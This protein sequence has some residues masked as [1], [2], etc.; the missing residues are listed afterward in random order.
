MHENEKRN[1]VIALSLKV[2]PAH[3][4]TVSRYIHISVYSFHLQ[5]DG[6]NVVTFSR[7]W[8]R[9]TFPF[10]NNKLFRLL[11]PLICWETWLVST[12]YITLHI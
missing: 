6:N 8:Q 1:W 10:G 2:A 4:D 12:L 11:Q 9:W 7:G 3:N 5:A